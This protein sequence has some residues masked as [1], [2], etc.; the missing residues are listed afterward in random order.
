MNNRQASRRRGRGNNNRAPSGGNRGGFDYQNRVDN[1]ARGNASQM[2]E[3]YKK[4]A[5][6]A[7]MNGDRVNAEYYFQFADHYFRVL[8]DFRSRQEARQDDRR[9]RDRDQERGTEDEFVM[10]AVDE[11]ATDSESTS[12]DDSRDER[13]SGNREESQTEADAFG[14][15]DDAP[16]QR[17]VR[18]QRGPRPRN[19]RLAQVRSESGEQSDRIDSSLLPP[20]ISLTSDADEEKV[21]RKP[22]A[23][24]PR[25]A[26]AAETPDAAE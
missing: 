7:Q 3:K 8:A 4:L 5:H 25:L 26:V 15:E 1:R 14:D 2:L 20:S 13:Y 6:D 24:R 16:Q 11:G 23:R 10:D 19:E 18:S 12:Y 9:G 21:V 17:R 22:R